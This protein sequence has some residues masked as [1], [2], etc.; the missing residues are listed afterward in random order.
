[1]GR[2]PH[3]LVIDP[4]PARDGLEARLSALGAATTVARGL[5]DAMVQ[6]IIRNPVLI[7]ADLSVPGGAGAEC[8]RRLAELP[9]VRR[10]P[11]LTIGPGAD[12][13]ASAD[14]AEVAERVRDLLP[15]LAPAPEGVPAPP[16][17]GGPA[18][19]A[20]PTPEPPRPQPREAA[21][22]SLSTVLDRLRAEAA[23]ATLTVR[24]ADGR[25]GEVLVRAGVPIHA[26]TTDGLAGD[27]AFDAVTAWA[28]AAVDEGPPPRPETPV[29]LTAPAEPEPAPE[30]AATGSPAAPDHRVLALLEEL[31][32]LGVVR[33]TAP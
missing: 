11:F 7:V 27:A 16:G 15:D 2:R 33:R 5:H 28:G 8:R 30:P 22:A 24:G 23:D 13:P 31:E 12:L 17:P 3:I 18:V 14:A 26:V 20:G 19:P 1:M 4:A 6:C 10:A 9:H 21:G 29:T 25:L 32:A